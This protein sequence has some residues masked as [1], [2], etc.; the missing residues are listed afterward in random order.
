MLTIS[1]IGLL[2]VLLFMG[3]PL[4]FAIGAS[5]MVAWTSAYFMALPL[6]RGWLEGPRDDVVT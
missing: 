1:I 6:V 3:L 5:S 4:V 2:L